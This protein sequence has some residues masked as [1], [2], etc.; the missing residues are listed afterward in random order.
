M[1]QIKRFNIMVFHNIETH[2]RAGLTRMGK[3][4]AI[5]V[6]PAMM[7]VA[8]GVAMIVSNGS[9][10]LV[11][12]PGQALLLPALSGPR[13]RNLLKPVSIPGVPIR[14]S[15]RAARRS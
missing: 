4:G 7:T 8:R 1:S 9:P 3:A 12:D 6:T 14:R 10:I 11:D 13:T 5:V 15:I 2:G